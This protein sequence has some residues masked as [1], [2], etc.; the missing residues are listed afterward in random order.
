[1][2]WYERSSCDAIGFL[3]ARET[4]QLLLV[5][6]SGFALTMYAMRFLDV[7]RASALSVCL[8]GLVSVPALS[9]GAAQGSGTAQAVDSTPVDPDEV[10]KKQIDLLRE[11]EEEGVGRRIELF[12]YRNAEFIARILN[13]AADHK[14][15]TSTDGRGDRP[16]GCARVL[17]A[18]ETTAGTTV[19][20]G[21]D[22][23]LLLYGN[24]EY[25]ERSHR[26]IAPL[27]LPLPGLNLQIW[28]VQVSSD[29]SEDLAEAMLMINGEVSRTQE[30]LRETTRLFQLKAQEALSTEDALYEAPSMLSLNGERSA[31]LEQA[32][33]HPSAGCYETHIQS[34][35]KQAVPAP[36]LDVSDLPPQ[37][38]P[39]FYRVLKD[40]GLG[41]ALTNEQN[42]SMIGVFMVGQ[43]AENPC[44]F[45][46]QLYDFVV[47]Q[48][49]W[50]DER[51][52][53]LK[54]INSPPFERLFRSRGLKPKCV[55]HSAEPEK[56]EPCKMWQW[57]EIFPG[58]VRRLSNANRRATLEFGFSFAHFLACQS[59][60]VDGCDATDL[61]D[62]RELQQTSAALNSLIQQFSGAFRRDVEEDIVTPSLVRIQQ[63]IARFK[64]V[65]YAQAGRTVIS[66]LSG[67]TTKI[68]SKAFSVASVGGP[69][70]SIQE[71]LTTASEL[72]TALS[73]FISPIPGGELSSD[74]QPGGD[75]PAALA[76]IPPDPTS[77]IVSR[78]LGLLI[79]FGAEETRPIEIQTGTNLM[80]TSGVLRD[81]NSAEL[82]ISLAVTNPSFTDTST[83]GDAGNDASPEQA[84]TAP[85]SRIGTQTVET[86]VYTSALDFFDLSAFSSQV[87]VSGG[88][89]VAFPVIGHLWTAIFG[90]VPGLGRLF[91]YRAP[92]Q[93]VTHESL[94]LTNSF[95]TPTSL[96]LARLYI[97]S[98]ESINMYR[99]TEERKATRAKMENYLRNLGN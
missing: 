67:V 27:D 87:S 18:D 22:N 78:L 83:S 71:R 56:G 62:P 10:C 14:P 49:I 36:E 80:F 2:S 85:F 57:E 13:V 92:N 16:L 47:N 48:N 98:E 91:T 51:F 33:S 24:E 6:V 35:V 1:M 54:D 4:G 30:L 9:Q 89:K 84:A 88:R 46:T 97:P 66:T 28:G 73:G 72:S 59:T 21:G 23:I 7:L 60:G 25:V 95:I 20:Q 55:D 99:D 45:Y 38:D 79:A 43:A 50:T 17:T 58:S 44:V 64:K 86:S 29:D 75:M 5:A 74:D 42:L 96:G 40:L 37:I 68:E 82:N 94:L 15:T 61:Y 77:L 41:G 93:T 70:P 3:E 65:E 12:Y 8:S 32:S 11:Q 63:R 39:E 34:T 53:Y 31:S 52:A 90:D 81:L 76:S 26:I 69:Q 19:G